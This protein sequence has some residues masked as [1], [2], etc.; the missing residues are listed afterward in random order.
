VPF[1]RNSNDFVFDTQM[2]FQTVAFGFKLSEVS[3]STRY[4][5]GASSINF[6]RSMVYGLS[7]LSVAFKYLLHKW[8][9]RKNPLFRC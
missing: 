5:E 4:F 2:I 3:V 7:T 6:R 1:L 8:G 9:I